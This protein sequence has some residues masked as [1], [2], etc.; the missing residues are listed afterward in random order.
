MKSAQ[1]QQDNASRL[2]IKT[3][4]RIEGAYAPATIRAFGAH[5]NTF[6]IYCKE[7]QTAPLSTHPSVVSNYINSLSD[8]KFTSTYIRRILVLISTIHKLNRLEDPTKDCDVQLAM[9]KM[10]RKLGRFSKQVAAI[11]KD[12]LQKML[13]ATGLDLRGIRDRALLQV[14]YDTLCRRSELVDLMVQDI[15]KNVSTTQQRF[16]LSIKLRKSKSDQ[17]SRG[18][19]LHLSELGSVALQEWLIAANL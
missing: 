11:T 18:K 12:I 15:T 9:R 16:C 19:W 5:F 14:A 2:L 1:L 3:L 6:I 7:N 4:Q 17:N 8:G 13:L 10:H